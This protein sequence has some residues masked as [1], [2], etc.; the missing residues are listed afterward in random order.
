MFG[1]CVYELPLQLNRLNDGLLVTPPT[2]SM[3]NSQ[4]KR[5]ESLYICCVTLK[6]DPERGFARS[7]IERGPTV[8]EHAAHSGRFKERWHFVGG[9]LL[10]RGHTFLEAFHGELCFGLLTLLFSPHFRFSRRPQLALSIG[11]EQTSLLLLPL[12]VLA[13]ERVEFGCFCQKRFKLRDAGHE[14]AVL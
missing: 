10:P 14:L 8:P 4:S 3:E 13:A 6:T 5:A 2:L 7:L 12:F 11:S 1:Q 9:H